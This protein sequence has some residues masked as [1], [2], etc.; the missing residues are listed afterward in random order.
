MGDEY[1]MVGRPHPMINGSQRA[2]RIIKEAN[3]PQVAVLLLDFILGYN[4]SHD[5][6]GELVDAI[7]KAKEIS[8]KQERNLEVVASICGTQGDP[9]DLK[10]QTQLLVDCGV[11]VFSSNA[12]ATRYC[13]SL[14]SEVNH[15]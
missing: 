6:V 5:P 7:N 12:Q 15:D 14:L 9:Q 10:M 4:S 2:L 13:I 1:F 3:D 11:K 8:E